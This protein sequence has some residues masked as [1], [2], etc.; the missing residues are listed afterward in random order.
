M[1]SQ[2]SCPR[3][4]DEAHHLCELP[5]R[6]HVLERP[7]QVES[8]DEAKP[9]AALRQRSIQAYSG[10]YAERKDTTMSHAQAIA[11][12]TLRRWM[13]ALSSMMAWPAGSSGL[14]RRGSPQPSSLNSCG[15]STGLELRGHT[16]GGNRC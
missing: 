14:G 7:H 2:A 15:H 13:R 16:D 10:L 6:R 3:G 5:R 1:A 4:G 12:R 8:L 11:R 9:V